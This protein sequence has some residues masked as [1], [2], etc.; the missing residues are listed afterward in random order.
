MK[1]IQLLEATLYTAG[2]L[3]LIFSVVQKPYTQISP[4]QPPVAKPSA[5]QSTTTTASAP[6]PGPDVH[7]QEAPIGTPGTPS[8]L[9]IGLQDAPSPLPASS[10]AIALDKMTSPNS[11]QARVRPE[12]SNLDRTHRR[13]HPSRPPRAALIKLPE[14]PSGVITPSPPP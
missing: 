7:T 3:T 6:S 8:Q 5:S 11:D 12:D 10:E 9:S 1:G 13:K 2:T 4:I 14:T